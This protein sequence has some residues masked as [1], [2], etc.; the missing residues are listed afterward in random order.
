MLVV[1]CQKEGCTDPSASNYDPTVTKEDGS[2]IPY[3]DI[4]CGL[5]CRSGSITSDEVWTSNEIYEVCG[6]LIVESGVTLTIEAGTI[7]KFHEGTGSLA[8]M[9]IIAKGGKINAVGN[10]N[11]PIIF[12]SILDNIQL[13]DVSG[14]NLNEDNSG[15]WGGLVILGKAPISAM[16]GDVNSQL[17]GIP[18]VDAYGAFGGNDSTDDSGVLD[19]VSIR[20]AGALIGAGN[21]INGLTL[22][23]VG[24]GTSLS[25]I[26]IVACMDDGLEC[27]GGTVNVDDLMIG[28]A[29]DDGLDLDMNYSGMIQDFII[30]QNDESDE[31]I[32]AG[33]PEGTTYTDGIFTLKNGTLL[34]ESGAETHSVFNSK[35]K[36]LIDNIAFNGSISIAGEYDPS[37]SQLIDNCLFYLLETNP[38]LVFSACNRTSL[39]YVTGNCSVST[40]DAAAAEAHISPTSTQGN[41][42]TNVSWTWLGANGKL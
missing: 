34:M 8:S 19:F 25:N 29:G 5:V 10:P 2:C 17:E 35:A 18:A 24:S 16:D 26:E 42:N 33:G 20:H 31:A 41:T 1:S 30:L 12:T 15:L 3:C 6:K 11:A 27:L 23:G 32:E 7:I 9:L 37:C 22:G 36:G 4:N 39:T 38:R 21:E 14:T 40:A 28:Y 13:G